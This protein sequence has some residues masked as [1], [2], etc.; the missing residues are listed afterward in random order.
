MNVDEYESLPTA[1]V[2]VHMTAGAIAGIMEHT[3]MYPLDSVKVNFL[4]SSQTIWGLPY[5]TSQHGTRRDFTIRPFQSKLIHNYIS[6]SSF[7]SSASRWFDNTALSCTDSFLDKGLIQLSLRY[8]QSTQS[9][10]FFQYSQMFNIPMLFFP[11]FRGFKKI[12]IK[13][14]CQKCYDSLCLQV[15]FPNRLK[16]LR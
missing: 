8:L 11:T 16:S 15:F 7:E 13:M 10:T 5:I 12:I 1:S 6:Q 4:P 2:G 14:H 9:S 3:I